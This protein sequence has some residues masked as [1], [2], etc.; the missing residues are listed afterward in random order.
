MTE[1]DYLIETAFCRAMEYVAMGE[2]WS[3]THRMISSSF[4]TLSDPE[5]ASVLA[6]ALADALRS[7]VERDDISRTWFVGRANPTTPTRVSYEDMANP[8]REG[9]IVGRV[10]SEYRVRFDDGEETV[11]DLRQHGWRKL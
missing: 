1:H 4:P 7:G 6:D 8:R 10:G 9:T 3:D 2:T 11:S 5:V